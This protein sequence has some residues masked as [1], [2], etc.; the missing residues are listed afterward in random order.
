MACDAMEM[1]PRRTIKYRRNT[2]TDKTNAIKLRL[3][4]KKDHFTIEQITYRAF[5]TAEHAAGDEALL[6]HQFRTDPAFVPQLD[7]VAELDGRIVGNIMYS[8]SKI[9]TDSGAEIATLTFGPVSVLPVYQKRS[10]GATLIRHTL[11]LGKDLGYAAVLI[12]G[13]ESYYPRFGFKPAL[14]YGIL[15]SGGE[16]FPAFMALPL[17]DGALDGISGR[18]YYADIFDQLDKDEAEALNKKLSEPMDI[19]EYIGAQA[20]EIRPLL[21]E[22]RMIIRAAAPDAMEKISWQMP[23]FWQG[24]NIIHFAVGKK[25]IGVYPGGEATTAFAGRL[26]GYKTSKGAIQFPMDKPID[27]ELIG[28]IVRWRLENLNGGPQA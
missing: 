2:M 27:F 4:R 7:F 22:I 5:L 19:D 1:H 28:D 10:V 6:A 16:S 15:T 13:H 14:E 11:E 26:T 9:V 23:T 21:E 24:E 25:H 12:Y 8:K 3:E 17:H 20:E 18:F